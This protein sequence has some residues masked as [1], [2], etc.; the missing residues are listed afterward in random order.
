MSKK[1]APLV[2]IGVP[3]SDQVGNV[4]IDWSDARNDIQLPL[5]ASMMRLSVKGQPVDVARNEIGKA[6]LEG[7]A[8]WLLFVGSDNIVPPNIFMQLASHDVDIINGVYWTK[9]YPKTPYIWRGTQRGPY[10]DWKIGEFFQID[11]AGMDATLIK[12]DVLR[13][14]EYPWWNCDW[15]WEDDDKPITLSTEDFYFYTKAM[16]AGYKV[17][18]DST[19]QVGHQDRH[20]GVIYGLTADMP[21]ARTEEREQWMGKQAALEAGEEYEGE[22]GRL[23]ADIGSGHWSEHFDGTVHRFDGDE[24][25]NPDFRCDI[26]K[27]PQ[28]DELYD[29]VRVSHV[30]EHFR[31]AEAP[32]LMKE[33]L[34]ILK[35]GGKM[36]LCVPNFLWA[37]QRLVEHH[38]DEADEVPT[39]LVWHAWTMVYG[40]LEPRHQRIREM[41][42]GNGYTERVLTNLLNVVEGLGSFEIELTKDDME[43]RCTIIKDHT[44]VSQSILEWWNEAEELGTT[45][46]N[47]SNRP[48]IEQSEPEEG[49]MPGEVV[50]PETVDD[51]PAGAG[52]GI[53]I[54]KPESTSLD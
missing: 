46:T 53:L 27:L 34:R 15:T 44:P 47:L 10:T 40:S 30:L 1:I 12:T 26:A 50:T 24:T 42:H 38:D 43:L 18:C 35:P 54:D 36:V 2:C 23:C 32:A 41:A 17:W 14:L 16:A 13:K 37:I 52:G 11:M 49:V 8:D 51:V 20:T 9:Q 39:N 25:T 48:R 28:P 45:T 3:V 19:V 6:A 4:S 7:G 33:W 22:E 21:Q 5:G 31:S 29:E